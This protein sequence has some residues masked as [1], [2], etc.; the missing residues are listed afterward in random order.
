[1]VCTYLVSLLGGQLST[2]LQFRNLD[3]AMER[4]VL[5]V[6][7]PR[8][9]GEFNPDVRLSDPSNVDIWL[10]DGRVELSRYVTGSTDYA[11]PRQMLLTTLSVSEATSSVSE[12]FFCRTGEYTTVELTC[13]PGFLGCTVDFWQDERAKPRGGE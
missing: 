12:S 11:P 7:V 2:V 13:A 10:L 8:A 9:S 1:M 5:H 6:V 4:C 3:Y